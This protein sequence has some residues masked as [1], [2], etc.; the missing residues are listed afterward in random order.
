MNTQNINLPASFRVIGVGTGIEEVINKVK[1]LGLD[2]VSAEIAEDPYECI[3]NDED[4]LTIIIFTDLE[5]TA[6]RIANNE[7]SG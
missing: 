6:N 3:P 1:S 5:E 7:S 4:K 2:G